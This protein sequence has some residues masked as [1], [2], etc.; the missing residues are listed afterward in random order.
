MLNYLYAAALSKMQ[1][2]KRKK[3]YK[4]TIINSESSSD[5]AIKHIIELKEIKQQRALIAQ[6]ATHI[7]KNT[8]I[9]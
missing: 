1:S 4:N 7:G 5:I 3:A 8:M 2:I 6:L 9:N